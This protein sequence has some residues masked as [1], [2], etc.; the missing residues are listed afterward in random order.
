MNNRNIKLAS[1]NKVYK[2]VVFTSLRY[3]CETWILYIKLIKQLECFHI[4][5]YVN[6]CMVK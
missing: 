6:V 4:E 2:A 3:G 1:K 5:C